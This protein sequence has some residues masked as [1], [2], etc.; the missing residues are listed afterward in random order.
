V[1]PA[2]A[3]IAAR[4][5]AALIAAEEI[6]EP[7]V[8]LAPTP[9][10]MSDRDPLRA[11]T[12]EA[13]TTLGWR[14]RFGRLER[15]VAATLTV[16][17]R[18]TTEFYGWITRDGQTVGVLAATIGKEAVLAVRQPDSTIR[19]SNVHS[20]RL[21]E[22]LVAQTPDIAPGRAKPLTFSPAE[23][24]ATNRTGRVR[25]A[26]GVG[27]RPASPEVRRAKALIALPTTGAGE[28]YTA[29]RDHTGR[30]LADDQPVSYVDSVD[31]RY[32][33]R[34]LPGG[35]VSVRP[36]GRADLVAELQAKHR[37]L[38]A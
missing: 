9:V 8:V 2:P 15:E 26:A 14:D 11:E 32:A 27:L 19:L 3:S 34:A 37:E 20:E 25:T 1:L 10:W 17:C 30:R 7:H 31:G 12:A 18:P 13:M 21:A 6:G 29:K 38:R 36:V 28:L 24:R 16:L 33:E 22:Q 35:Q 23:L 5:L 4:T